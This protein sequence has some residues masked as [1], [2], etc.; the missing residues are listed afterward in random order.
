MTSLATQAYRQNQTLTMPRIDLVLRIYE[1]V[2]GQLEVALHAA[3]DDARQRL[4][5]AQ[6]VIGGLASEIMPTSDVERNFLRLYEY[7][8]HCLSTGTAA[9]IREALRVLGILREAFE[10]ARPEALE[11]ERTGQIPPLDDVHAVQ[12]VG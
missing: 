11:L 2:I 9:R 1:G 6:V 4:N 8:L 5:R 12:T 3:P 10:Q 7:V